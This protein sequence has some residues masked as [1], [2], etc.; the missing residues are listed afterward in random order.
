MYIYVFIRICFLWRTWTIQK[1]NK[2]YI[3]LLQWKIQVFS[4]YLKISGL[5]F[6]FCKLTYLHLGWCWV[7]LCQ[8]FSLTRERVLN[9]WNVCRTVKQTFKE[10]HMS[11]YREFSQG[12]FM[13]Y[14]VI[15]GLGGG[16]WTRPWHVLKG[17]DAEK[18][19]VGATGVQTLA[20]LVTNFENLGRSEAQILYW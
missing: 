18:E 16:L 3:Y 13:R 17:L 20:L 11:Y 10:K 19:L 2:I 14:G 15:T 12:C 1:K 5:N 7:C 8:D 6:Q 9:E 4:C